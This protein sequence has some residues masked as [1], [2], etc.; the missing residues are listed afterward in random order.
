VKVGDFQW[1]RIPP[2]QSVARP[3]AIRAAQE[4]SSGVTEVDRRKRHAS[5]LLRQLCVNT[6]V[7]KEKYF[8]FENCNSLLT[9]ELLEANKKLGN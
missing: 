8:A 1:V 5:A 2:G 3:E 6:H 7:R 4:V 9:K